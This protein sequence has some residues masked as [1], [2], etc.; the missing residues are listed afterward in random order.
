MHS[1][2]LL[3]TMTVTS[4]LFGGG[5]HCGTGHC[6]QPTWGQACVAPVSYSQPPYYNYN[7]PCASC[8]APTDAASAYA[9]PQAAPAPQ[10]AASPPSQAAPQAALAPQAGYY[11][12]AAYYYYPAA[13]AC[14]TGNCPSR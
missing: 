11:N 10:M 2:I 14:P 12:A 7:Q 6:G 9:A 5:R 4:G 1:I 13:P 3:T 8:A